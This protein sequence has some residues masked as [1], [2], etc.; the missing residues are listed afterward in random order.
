MPIKPTLPARRIFTKTSPRLSAALHTCLYR[1]ATAPSWAPSTLSNSRPQIPSTRMRTIETHA[2]INTNLNER[3]VKFG[4]AVTDDVPFKEKRFE[5]MPPISRSHVTTEL[6][7]PSEQQTRLEGIPSLI[8]YG[9]HVAKEH[10]NT[11]SILRCVVEA[12]SLPSLAHFLTLPDSPRTPS[13]TILVNELP[14]IE[15]AVWNPVIDAEGVE[16]KLLIASSPRGP[17]NERF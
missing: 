15:E 1:Q 10:V 8:A 17:D 9:E 3:I 11:F 2:G 16:S 12:P 7:L 6:D 14:T 13:S 5:P 4:S